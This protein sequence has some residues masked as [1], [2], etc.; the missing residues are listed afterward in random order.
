MSVRRILTW[1][2]RVLHQSGAVL[3]ADLSDLGRYNLSYYALAVYTPTP[4][5]AGSYD[6]S[7]YDAANYGGA[8]AIYD[9]D[10][11]DTGTYA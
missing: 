10:T 6:L 3:Y 5:P 11:Y 9:S 1:Q 2:G 7:V 8:A 4:S